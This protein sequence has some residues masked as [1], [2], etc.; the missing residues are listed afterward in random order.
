MEKELT[1]QVFEDTSFTMV[2][3]PYG[4][5]QGFSMYVILPDD[6]QAPIREFA[7]AFNQDKLNGALSRMSVRSVRLTI[8]GW[9]YDYSID[10]MRP[11]LTSLGMGIAFD[12]DRADLS[13]MFGDSRTKAVV[14]KV[15]H[16]AYIKVN[17]KG[18]RAAVVTVNPLVALGS[19]SRRLSH[20]IRADHPFLY[21]IAEKK[22]NTLLFAGIV[23]DPAKN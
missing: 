22:R 14:S 12:K 6:Q 9:E 17:E 11:V 20:M 18:T 8:P 23:E 5:G 16:K 7:A 15:I 10:D 19:H 4:N 1:T 21:L 13:N 2:E 3:L